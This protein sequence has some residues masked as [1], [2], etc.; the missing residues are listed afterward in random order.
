MGPHVLPLQNV[1]GQKGWAAER[2]IKFGTTSIKTGALEWSRLGGSMV[3]HAW[4][5]EY[6]QNERF[7]GFIDGQNTHSGVLS[8]SGVSAHPYRLPFPCFFAG[9]AL[10]VFEFFACFAFLAVS[11]S[12]GFFAYCACYVC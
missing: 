5:H 6:Q 3:R 10:L 2:Q 8:C 1:C 11:A 9:F 7:M 12:F 4:S